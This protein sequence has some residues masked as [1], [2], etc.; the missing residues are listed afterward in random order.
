MGWIGLYGIG[1][2]YDYIIKFFFGMLCYNGNGVRKCL[3]FEVIISI[4]CIVVICMVVCIWKC[5][6]YG[7]YK[8]NDVVIC[9]MC[10][11]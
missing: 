6:L 10:F 3:V 9:K 2:I 11:L 7:L 5:I 8:K 1:L 4:I